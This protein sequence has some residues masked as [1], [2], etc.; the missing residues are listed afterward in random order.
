MEVRNKEPFFI[1]IGDKEYIVRQGT[2]GVEKNK[3]FFF[4]DTT[5]TACVGYSKEFCLN[6]PS[7][8]SVSRNITDREV[9]IRDVNKVLDSIK[10]MVTSDCYS[11]I[12][13]KINSL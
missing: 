1:S 12:V 10:P 4:Y 8:F 5:R 7:L 11:L 13:N 6:F 3:I 9:S 2:V